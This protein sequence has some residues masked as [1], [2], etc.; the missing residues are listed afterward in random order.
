LRERLEVEANKEQERIEAQIAAMFSEA[1]NHIA[2]TKSKA[3]AT[4][5]QIAIEVARAVV[6]R[7]I[8]RDMTTEEVKRTFARAA[9]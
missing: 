3:L 7:L 5:D 4:I 9:E 1:E 2:A 8:G 6:S